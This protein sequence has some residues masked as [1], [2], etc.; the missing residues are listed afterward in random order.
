LNVVNLFL[1]NPR[2][3]EKSRVLLRYVLVA[4]ASFTSGT[5]VLWLLTDKA[6]IFYLISGIIGA[7]IAIGV[8][9][10]LNETWTFSHRH[11][12]GFTSSLPK[13]FLKYVSSKAVGLIIGYSILALGTQ[14]LGLHY[15]ISNLMGISISF[16]WNLV[17]NYGWVWAKRQK[18]LID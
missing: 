14:V 9:F 3:R 10:S 12:G 6:K 5:A 16:I 15:M 17:M 7:A 11:V 2:I 13:R 4:L 8:D 1:S 18:N